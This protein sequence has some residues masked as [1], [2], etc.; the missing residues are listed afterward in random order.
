MKLE[1]IKGKRNI[2]ITSVHPHFHLASGYQFLIV[3][4]VSDRKA[5]KIK[6]LS[7]KLTT[8]VR[9]SVNEKLMPNVSPH[10]LLQ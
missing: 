4:I 3:S 8:N 10:Q 1:Q 2:Q 7:L 9:N 6:F 5:E